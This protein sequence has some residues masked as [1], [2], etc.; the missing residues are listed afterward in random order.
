MTNLLAI[1]PAR[2]GSR[3]IPGKN[4]R[5]VAGK[6]LLL[7]TLETVTASGIATDIVV[8]TEN[9]QIADYCR[10]RGYRASMR[11]VRLSDD[12][13]TL[14]EVA[15]HVVESA[16]WEGAVAI[17]QPTCPLVTPETLQ[18]AYWTWQRSGRDWA[19]T[20]VKDSHTYWLAGKLV[21]RRANRQFRDPLAREVGAAQFL[22]HHHLATRGGGSKGLITIPTEEGLDIDTFADLV[23]A[24]HHLRRAHVHFVVAAGHEIGTGHFHRCLALAKALDNHAITWEWVGK[25]TTQQQ[26]AAKAVTNGVSLPTRSTHRVVVFDCL[27]PSVARLQHF[28]AKGFKVVVLEDEARISEPHADLLVNE[29]LDPADWKYATTREEFRHLPPREHVEIGRK[30][31]ITFGG[32]DPSG[33]AVRV[34]EAL[35]RLRRSVKTTV[36]PSGGGASV[37]K[38]MRAADVVIT[39]RGRTVLEAAASETPC[40]SIAANDREA[41]HVEIPGVRYLGTH[42]EI[43]DGEIRRAVK[44]VLASQTVRQKMVVK[45]RA[46]IDG[47]GLPRLVNRIEE[48]L[49]D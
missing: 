37:A 28:R 47:D 13:T 45:A 15:Q 32:T 29:L 33:L 1:I 10:L 8:S 12:S 38:E 27:A 48:L 6:P 21:G 25:P 19:I 3:S 49:N 44:R 36:L 18:R 46:A 20:A 4:M 31:L 16:G 42:N 9:E 39:S 34:E 43:P 26:L 22:T 7:R 14:F 41:R 5:I 24:E 11:L 2:G 23:L 30:V 17:F 40:I 35:H